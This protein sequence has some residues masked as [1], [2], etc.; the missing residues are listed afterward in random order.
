MAPPFLE[1]LHWRNVQRI[2]VLLP[3]TVVKRTAPPEE[4]VSEIPSKRQSVASK[5]LSDSIRVVMHP[6]GKIV[7]IGVARPGRTTKNR[8]RDERSGANVITSGYQ[9]RARALFGSLGVL[10]FTFKTTTDVNIWLDIH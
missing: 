6:A 1:Q 3:L 5:Q 2:K 4:V 8:R 7:Q 9:R 10:E